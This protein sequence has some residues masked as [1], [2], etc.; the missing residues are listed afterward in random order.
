MAISLVSP[1]IK[2]TETDFVS[3]PVAVSGSAGGFAGQFR[4]GPIDEA[5]L[6]TS[7]TDLVS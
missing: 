6:V 7:E 3:S 5:T 4:W 1:G 2:I